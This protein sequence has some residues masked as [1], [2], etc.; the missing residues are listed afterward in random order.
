M[1]L[2]LIRLPFRASPVRLQLAETGAG[3][4]SEF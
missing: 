1:R 4:E 3:P 2:V